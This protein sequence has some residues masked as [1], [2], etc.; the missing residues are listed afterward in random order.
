MPRF[1]RHDLE[2][3]A[4]FRIVE[5]LDFANSQIGLHLSGHVGV[6]FLLIVQTRVGQSEPTSVPL[7]E[8]VA[9]GTLEQVSAHVVRRCCLAGRLNG[10]IDIL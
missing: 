3:E 6:V 10:W 1:G 8:R 2:S 4:S 7:L 9:M 5:F